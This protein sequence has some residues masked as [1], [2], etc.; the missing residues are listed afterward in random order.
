MASK[1][2]HKDWRPRGGDVGE[3]E[4]VSEAEDVR[5]VNLVVSL[6]NTTIPMSIA[7]AETRYG[8]RPGAIAKAYGGS[9]AK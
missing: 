2:F 4:E 5:I 9:L 3:R 7:M 1:V 8:S 6:A